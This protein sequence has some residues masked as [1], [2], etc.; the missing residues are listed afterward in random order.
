MNA[1]KWIYTRLRIFMHSFP[2]HANIPARIR[3]LRLEHSGPRGKARFARDI[4]VSAS[5]Y[6]YYE[7]DRVPPADLLVRI[8]DLTGAD[9]RWLLTGEAS[10]PVVAASHPA[11]ARVA[12]LLAD[13]PK[14]AEPLTA[15]VDLLS[16]T[17]QFPDVGSA[18]N[19]QETA[20]DSEDVARPSSAD[21]P[22]AAFE[23]WVPVLGRS[24]AGVPCFWQDAAAPAGVTHLADLVPRL[25]PSAARH[26]QPAHSREA[27]RAGETS[28]QVV[29]LDAPRRPGT[30][31]FIVA[32]D[33]AERYDSPFAVR[34]DGASMAPEIAHGDFVLLSP[35][36]PAE[37]GKPAVV[38]LADQ[39]GVTCKLYRREADRVH[40]IPINEQFA[41]TAH[42]AEQVAWAL[43]VLARIRPG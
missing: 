28:V 21:D 2:S 29:T 6:D 25:S 8:A 30:A 43:K 17:M 11:V 37:Q 23:G 5:T 10:S 22:V 34:I 7:K 14:A 42:S 13:H 27:Q 16:Q 12:K 15:F 33:L 9:L 19:G 38:Q 39:I 3:Q 32:A 35:A 40:L 24:A 31:E 41:P 4:G 20:T 18:A 36:C 26:V 1:V